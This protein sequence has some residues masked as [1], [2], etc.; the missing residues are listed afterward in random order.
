[1]FFCPVCQN[2]YEIT[3]EIG[4]HEKQ[5]GGAQAE[6]NYDKLV[7]KI[8]NN[9]E[10]TQ[11]DIIGIDLAELMKKPDIKK[12]NNMA[13][14][15]IKIKINELKNNAANSGGKIYFKCGYCKNVEPILPRT[16]IFSKILDNTENE[17]SNVDYKYMFNN[18][19]LPRTKNYECPNEKC[20]TKVEPDRKEAIFFREVNSYKILYQCTACETIF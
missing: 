1:M 3:D 7:N 15:D 16:K 12:L 11:N 9:E 19:I 14:R 5:S 18:K 4:I 10:I 13:K 6:D 8:T 20:V 17:C 2:L